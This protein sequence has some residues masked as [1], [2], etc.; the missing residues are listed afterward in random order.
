MS[1]VS[2]G[3]DAA[4]GSAVVTRKPLKLLLVEDSKA[5]AELLCAELATW[6][7]DVTCQRV[8]SEGAF[9]E[10]LLNG[11]W[12]VIISDY[13]MP[14][15]AGLRALTLCMEHGVDTP[16]VFVSGSA[17]DER[18]QRGI[19]L[20]AFEYLSKDQMAALE[21]ALRDALAANEKKAAERS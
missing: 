6:G 14:S 3:E 7:Y 15:F 4:A 2:S 8:D 17:T 1:K 9:V 12:D 10:A 5:D 21:P 19:E 18:R 20:G 13:Q 11:A 16:F